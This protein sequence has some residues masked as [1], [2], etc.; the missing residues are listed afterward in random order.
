MTL[1]FD[2]PLHAVVNYCCLP[3]KERCLLPPAYVAYGGLGEGGIG[4]EG[5]GAMQSFSANQYKLI[6]K[7]IMDKKNFARHDTKNNHHI[8][9]AHIVEI[10]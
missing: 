3:H 5:G 9:L 10:I 7:P 2:G 8:V 6:S 1:G 4:G